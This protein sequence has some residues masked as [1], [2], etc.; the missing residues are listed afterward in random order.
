MSPYINLGPLH[1]RVLQLVTTAFLLFSALLL[2]AAN[3]AF[4]AEAAFTQWLISLW[5]EAQAMGVSRATFD[6]ATL[7]LE[8]DFS[9]PD[10]AIPG[11]S[12]APPRGQAEFVQTPADYLKEAN[13]ARLA[14]QGA[15]LREQ[16]RAALDGIEKRFGVPG[17]VVLAIWGR[18]TDFGNYKLPHSAIR[19]LA[20]QAYVGKRKDMFRQE[21]LLAL[22]MLQEGLVKRADMRSSW[23]GAMGLTQF[24]P[25]E[26]YG[27]GVDFDGDGRVDI[28][29]SVPDALASAAKQLLDKGWQPGRRWAYEAHAPQGF[30]CTQGVPE[31][32]RPIG[33][34]LKA[35]F[36]P[37]Y[38]RRLRADELAETASVLQPEGIYGP[39]FLAAKNYFV[40]KEY[41][42]SDLY[43]LFVGW[44]AERSHR[45]S[46]APFRAAV[47][48]A[49]ADAHRRRR[50]D[51]EGPHRPRPLS[52]QDRRQGR[53]AD[54]LSARR[55]PEGERSQARL[56][57]DRR[58]ARPHARPPGR[59]AG[60]V[61][62]TPALSPTPRHSGAP[63]R[64]EPGIHNPGPCIQAS[65]RGHGFWLACSGAIRNDGWM[66]DHPWRCAVRGWPIRLNCAFCS[67]LSEP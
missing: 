29:H 5:P 56:L 52:R 58:R 44:Q 7:G 53:H 10:L 32:V 1:P 67:S 28:W 37:A 66:A 62:V 14:A 2:T 60:A 42:F 11:R 64:R 43:V 17:P 9:L 39:A 59:R 20:T 48:R 3:H 63:Q 38:G 8:P 12:E 54:T 6:A 57:A 47:E 26:F 41:N 18:E 21:F 22:K 35:G 65:V 36:V 46:A 51:A 34:W 33:D 24:L 23:G 61:R 31:V 16:Y 4:A 19:V 25:S 49:R 13:I 40:I 50:G 55:L 45:R 27:H 15:K 30:D